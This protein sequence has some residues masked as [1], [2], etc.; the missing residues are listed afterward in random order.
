MR[1][2]RMIS[3]VLLLAPAAR[4]QEV[5]LVVSRSPFCLIGQSVTVSVATGLSM[6]EGRF[7][8]KY[9]PR[10]DQ[11]P[12]SEYVPFDFP[13][14]VPKAVDGLDALTEVT[15]IK[16]HAGNAAFD[17]TDC[18]PLPGSVRTLVMVSE[19]IR[20]MVFTFQLPRTL[21]QKQLTLRLTYFQPHYH[22]AGHE[23]SAYLPWLPDF[24]T[25]KNELLFSRDD[26]VVEF[27]TVGAVRLLRLSANQAVMT[28]TPREVKVHP[29]DQEVIAVA[30]EPEGEAPKTPPPKAPPAP[31]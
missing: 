1:S 18:V 17:P 10:F 12:P 28:D 24:E 13:V 3:L 4:A 27:Q 9:V 15:Q 8:F 19:D 2:L 20:A 21:L 29:V 26:F 31:N 7:E 23:V 30:V 11:V 6:V 5:A 22:F 16:L 14:L 25:L